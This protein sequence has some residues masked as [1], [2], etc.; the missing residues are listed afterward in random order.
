[1]SGHRGRKAGRP[2]HGT[3]EPLNRERILV[4]ASGLFRERGYHQTSI[5]AIADEVGVTAP[6]LYWHFDSKADILFEFLSGTLQ[7][8]TENVEAEVDRA[9]ADPVDRLRAFAESHTRLQLQQLD[10]AV[11]YG[12]LIFST[13]QLAR[14]L[15][16]E[17]V[18][19]LTKLQRRHIDMCRS[20][21]DEGTAV[22]QFDPGDSYAAALALINI[23]E[24]V[25]TWFRSDHR[26]SPDAVAK[27]HG[28]YA[29]R[30]LTA[31]RS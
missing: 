25:T 12:E 31:D 19:V 14:S 13:A 2:T 16:S 24:Y 9:G 15:A 18:E 1:M 6:A 23:C 3:A 28:E 8:F 27:L 30:M 11:A 26:L 20:I 29:V 5:A 17:Q 4:A 7:A 22:G 10:I 21:I